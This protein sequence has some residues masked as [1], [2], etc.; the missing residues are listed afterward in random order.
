[1]T[2]TL[3]ATDR[4]L[5]AVLALLLLGGG[6][7][8]LGYGSGNRLARTAA[9]RVDAPALGGVTGWSWWP[10]ASATAGVIVILLGAWLVLLHLRSRAVH[11]LPRGGG[12]I[13][14]AQLADAAAQDLGG[15]PAV[16]SAKA[17]THTHRGR[18]V[19]RITVGVTPDTGSETIH[20]LARH[21]G[22]EVRRAAGHDIAFQLLVETARPARVRRAVI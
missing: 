15:H 8:A 6:I 21:C 4:L 3:R 20:R 11:S 12:V 10:A 18:A 2:P 9:A 16:Q 5:T 19:V 7:W 13:D 17:T 14:V 22:A 1:M